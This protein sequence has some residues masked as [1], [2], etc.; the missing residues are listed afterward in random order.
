MNR[1]TL[2]LA[3]AGVALVAFGGAAW[4]T[5]HAEI[6]HES[7]A[8]TASTVTEPNPQASIPL[9]QAP[10]QPTVAPT[11]QDEPA[12]TAA[13]DTDSVVPTTTMES[14]VAQVA[15]ATPADEAPLIRPYSPVLG[16]VDAPVTIVEFF[17]PSCEA[18]RAFHPV[19]QSIREEFPTQV[20]IVLRY[21]AFHQGSDEAVRI[22]EA[23]RAQGMFEPVLDA[24][25]ERQPEWAPHSGPQLDLAWAIAGEAGLDVAAGQAYRQMPGVVAILNG[26][27]ADVEAVG[28]QQTPTFFINGE[29]LAEFGAEELVEAVREEVKV[30]R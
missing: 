6:S 16:P 29:P 24:L 5:S 4:L 15:A 23:A 22:L 3:T 14:A 2:V 13:P 1:F 8:T 27:A 26:D 19:L 25:F 30:A 18:C 10:S 17:D 20:R 7:L 12:E 9:Q 11:Q 28:I 21:A